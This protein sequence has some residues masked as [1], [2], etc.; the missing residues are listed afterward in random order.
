MAQNLD[1]HVGDTWV[2]DETVLKLDKGIQIWFWDIEDSKIRFLLASHM[3]VTRGI[4]DA[5]Q[6]MMKAYQ[7]AKKHPRAI[8]TDK[9]AA[10]LD[11][12]ELV[13][14]A[15]AKHV[16]SKGFTVE[17]NTN[18]IERF[19]GTLKARTKVMRGMHNRETARLIMDGWL[20]H[21][22]FF[23]PHE[24]LADRTPASVAKASFPYYSWKDVVIANNIKG[25]QCASI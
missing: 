14:G 6:L 17:P 15:D 1:V 7:T 13:F 2:A 12:I 20:V 18:L 22:N 25:Q 5:K 10:Y 16:Q 8:I 11:G 9:L 21:Y 24:S 3:S 23:R 19:H 4:Q